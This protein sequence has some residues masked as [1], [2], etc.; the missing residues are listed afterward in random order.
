MDRV[1]RSSTKTNQITHLSQVSERRSKRC[2]SVL[3]S[4]KVRSKNLSS[5]STM[6]TVK[7]PTTLSDSPLI[8]AVKGNIN[9]VNDDNIKHLLNETD[10]EN[11]LPVVENQVI[12]GRK[13]EISNL[14]D[15]ISFFID[16]HESGSIYI[17]GSPGTGKTAVTLHVVQ[18][19]KN[20]KQCDSI[21][22]NCMQ[23]GV[24]SEIYSRITSSLTS[25]K[26]FRNAKLNT[27]DAELLEGMLN[28]LPKKKTLLLVLDEIDQLSSRSQDILYRLV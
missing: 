7:Q 24:P 16:K 11:Q 28:K 8:K 12:I 1:L 10:V 5:R 27:V 18:N 6:M 26:L 4:T 9:S 14:T 21:Y 23:L 15:Q 20:L 22:I 3:P 17:S 13:S 2:F 25:M 19:F